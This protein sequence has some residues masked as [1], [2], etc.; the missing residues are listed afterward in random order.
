MSNAAS[1][2]ALRSGGQA[3]QDVPGQGQL[4][5]QGGV[6]GLGGDGGQGVELGLELLAFV[7]ELGEPVADAGAHGGGGG[8]GGVGGEFFLGQDLG[9]LRGLVLPDLGR[10]GGG[11]GVAVG[12]R[13]GVGGGELGGEQLGAAGAE[14]VVAEEQAGDRVQGGLGGL[15][16]AGVIRGR[17]RRACGLAGS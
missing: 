3:G 12:G 15:D 13:G 9:F 14:D 4:V 8:V 2:R 16:R 10:Q 1:S 5:E 6:G 11:L 7:V 17:R